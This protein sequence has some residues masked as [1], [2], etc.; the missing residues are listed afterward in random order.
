MSSSATRFYG[1]ALQGEELPQSK[2]DE[3]KVREIRE[4]HAAKE[5]LKKILDD[6]HSHEAL[7]EEFGVGTTTI[8]KVLSYETWRHVR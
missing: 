8:A 7:A 2:L 5:R 4:R 6:A 3:H 1:S